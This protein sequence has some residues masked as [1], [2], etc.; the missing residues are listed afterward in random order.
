M[1]IERDAAL[2]RLDNDLELYE[3]ICGIFCDEGRSMLDQLR[4]SLTAGDA[5][6]ALRTAHSLK[7][8]SANI[9]ATQLS[10]CAQKAE[11]ACIGEDLPQAL[12]ILPTLEALFRDVIAEINGERS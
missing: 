6:T 3:E 5:V 1:T 8:A 11:M 12:Q 4:E 2:E 7:S 10:S 9:G